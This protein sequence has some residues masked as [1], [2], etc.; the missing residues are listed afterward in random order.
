MKFVN[1]VKVQWPANYGL[2]FKS[3]LPSY[4]I[5]LAIIFLILFEYR[6]MRKEQILVWWVFPLFIQCSGSPLPSI[7]C[8]VFQTQIY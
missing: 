5:Q 2:L 8:I 7:T 6:E 4:F 1:Q 3:S